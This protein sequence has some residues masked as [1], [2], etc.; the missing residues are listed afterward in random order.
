M[1]IQNV[2]KINLTITNEKGE[3]IEKSCSVSS[4]TR[5]WKLIPYDDL[6]SILTSLLSQLRL[7]TGRKSYPGW[8]G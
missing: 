4:G 2:Y 3:M 1:S 6:E 5:P 8:L 7:E